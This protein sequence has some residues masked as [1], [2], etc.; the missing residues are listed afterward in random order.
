MSLKKYLILAEIEGTGYFVEIIEDFDMALVREKRFFELAFNPP[1]D[2][3][4]LKEE[5]KP[6]GSY[7]IVDQFEI[8]FKSIG[9]TSN[10][11]SSTYIIEIDDSFDFEK[12][13]TLRNR[14]Y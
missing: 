12:F 2:R 8:N 13:V 11:F 10:G 5:F 1:I 3:N 6:F 4:K 7:P 9:G 14:T